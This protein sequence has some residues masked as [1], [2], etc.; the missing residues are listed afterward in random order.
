MARVAVN[1]G[2]I[3]V[4]IEANKLDKLEQSGWWGWWQCN[5]SKYLDIDS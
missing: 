3:H 4:F 1:N 5:N 2:F